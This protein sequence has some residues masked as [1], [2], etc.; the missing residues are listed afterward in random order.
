MLAALKSEHNFY[1]KIFLFPKILYQFFI[2][3]SN[4]LWRYRINDWRFAVDKLTIGCFVSLRLEFNLVKIDRL[5]GVLNF[6]ISFMSSFSAGLIQSVELCCGTFMQLPWLSVHMCP[7]LS[8][9][10]SLQNFRTVKWGIL[11]LKWRK[12]K[13]PHRGV[14]LS[15]IKHAFRT[16][17]ISASNKKSI[18]S[19]YMYM[20]LICLSQFNL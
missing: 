20:W 10:T 1:L 17:Q 2:H 18:L 15:R 7:W 12:K 14:N 13:I 19:F 11:R 8:I 3:C 16:L 5:R 6:E 9:S 4:F